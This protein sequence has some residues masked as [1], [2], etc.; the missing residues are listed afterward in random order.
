MRS[1]VAVI[2]AILLILLV[3]V[4]VT[5]A[6]VVTRTDTVKNTFDPVDVNC[7]VKE[8]F[9]GTKKTDVSVKNTGTTAAYIRALVVVNWISP[10]GSVYSKVPVEG[11]DYTIK[12]G[13]GWK[14]SNVDGFW[15][16][17]SDIDPNDNTP[18]LIKT[19]SPVANGAPDGYSLSVSILASAI[20]SSP[21]SAVYDA[22]GVGANSGTLTV[23]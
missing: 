6:Y 14:K 17:I 9:D 7:E 3:A 10:T 22:W 2:V 4:G 20:Q 21:D 15:Y 23:N 8:T 11:D 1:M 13:S 16:C 12:Y 5:V 19:S 18:V